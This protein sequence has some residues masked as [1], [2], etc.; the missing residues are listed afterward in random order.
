M[1]R[2]QVDAVLTDGRNVAIRSPW[3]RGSH[4]DDAADRKRIKVRLLKRHV[5]STSVDA[6]DDDIGSLIELVEIPHGHDA[7]H[8]RSRSGIRAMK[9]QFALLT[10]Q[11]ALHGLEDVAA[12]AERPERCFGRWR[13][14]PRSVVLFP[15]QAHAGEDLEA[16][17]QQVALLQRSGIGMG[18]GQVDGAV[19][20]AGLQLPIQPCPRLLAHVPLQARLDLALGATPE[21]LGR[22]FAGA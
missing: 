16:T 19:A 10:T 1:L 5:V 12:F 11:R 20:R 6:V 15:G 14:V 8:D 3:W 2:S 13:E 18:T 4:F 7:A 21:P 17:E 22:E 9:H